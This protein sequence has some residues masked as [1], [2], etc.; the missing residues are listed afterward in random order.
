M[1]RAKVKYEE[2][3]PDVYVLMEQVINEHFEEIRSVE[4]PLKITVLMAGNGGESNEPC[5]KHHGA[6]CFALIRRSKPQDRAQNGPDVYIEIDENRWEESNERRRMAVLAHELRHVEF[7][8]D[9]GGGVKRD[10]YE[11]PVIR[12]V[13]DD[14]TLTGFEDVCEWYGED[15]V[16]YQCVRE[17]H[18]KLAQLG[19]SFMSAEDM[20]ESRPRSRGRKAAALSV[21]ATA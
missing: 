9:K 2:A 16:E 5:L 18:G 21:A 3:M 19:L 6:A 20:A 4:P 12:F 10:I 8:L 17:V 7:K 15:A 13:P 1:A 14:W 11:R